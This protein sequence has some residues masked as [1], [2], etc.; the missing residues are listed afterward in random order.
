[1]VALFSLNQSATQILLSVMWLHLLLSYIEDTHATD[2][3]FTSKISKY[4]QVWKFACDWE[5]NRI[6]LRQY[7]YKYS[8]AL[9]E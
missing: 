7:W 1:M 2:Y 4:L 3:I 5:K 9:L 8:D 6:T